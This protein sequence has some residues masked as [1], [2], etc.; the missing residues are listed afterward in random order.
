M[1]FQWQSTIVTFANFLTMKGNFDSYIRIQKASIK[2]T[3]YSIR[4]LIDLG[5]GAGMGQYP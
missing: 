2:T 4:D 1:D 3:L 5:K